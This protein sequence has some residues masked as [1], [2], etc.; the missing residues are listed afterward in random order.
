MKTQNLQQ[1]NGMLMSESRGN[2]SQ[3]DPIKFLTK[4]LESNL[5][6]YSDAYILVTGNITAAPSNA[7]TEVVFK[8]C[9]PFKNCR[10]EINDRFIDNA[11]FTNIIMLIYYS[12]TFGSL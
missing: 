8:N 3:D 2:Y 4:S 9:V 5:C 10:T 11:D 7:V 1:K 6:D 12:D